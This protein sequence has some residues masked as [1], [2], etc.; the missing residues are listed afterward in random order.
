MPAVQI[1]RYDIGQQYK[2]HADTLKDDQAGVRVATVRVVEPG[3]GLLHGAPS[4]SYAWTCGL[5]RPHAGALRC[6]SHG[7]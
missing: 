2:V 7:P 6:S 3:T 1:L 4:T 5:S